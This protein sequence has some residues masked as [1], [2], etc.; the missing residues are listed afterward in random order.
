MLAAMT[1]AQ[2]QTVTTDTRFAR[3]ATMAFGRMT[4]TGIKSA[5]VA[6]QGFCWAEHAQ[7][8]VDDQKTTKFMSNN[9]RIYRLEKLTPATKY[10]M[11]AF[12]TTKDGQTYYG[13]ALK[14]YTVPKGQIT[15]TIRDGGSADVKQR[16]TD[17][18]KTAVDWWNNLTE[19]KGF[20]TSVGYESGTPTADC[21]YGGWIRVGSNTSY[22][23]TGTIMHEMLHGCGVIPWADTEWSRHNLRSGVTGD[24][25]GTGLWLGDRVTEVVRFLDNSATAQ[26]NGDYQ[27]MWPYGINGAHEDNGS[28]LLYIGNSLICQALGEDGLQHTYELFAEP[29]YAFDQEDDVKYY[30][31]NES[32]ACGLYSSYLVPTIAGQ[33][34]WRTM[35]VEEALANDSAAWYIT[36]KP[37]NQYY[38]FRN[39]ATERYISYLGS[40]LRTMARTTPT[41]SDNFHLMKSRVDVAV[42]GGTIGKRGYWVIAPTQNWTPPCMT[43]AANGRVTTTTFNIANSA[44]TQRWLLLTADEALETEAE[45]MAVLKEEVIRAVEQVRALASVPHTEDE[46]GTDDAL[47]AELERIE[48]LLATATSPSELQTLTDDAR[49]AAMAFLQN[50]TPSDMAHPFDLTAMLVSPDMNSGEGW[51]VAPTINYSCGE[52]YEKAFD[53][54]QKVDGLPAGTYAF[55]AQAFQRPGRPESC[56]GTVVNAYIYAGSK[57]EKLAHAVSEAQ[58]RKLGGS[59]SY[60]GGK[61]IPNNMEAASIYF[62]KGLYE[63]RVL[64]TVDSDGG[65]LKAGLRCAAMNSYYWVIFDNF[66]LYYYGSKSIDDVT[67]IYD[68]PICDLPICNSDNMRIYD[69]QGRMVNGQ[70]VNGKCVNGQSVNGKSVRIVNGRKVVIR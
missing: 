58:V 8:T 21:S 32:E 37:T 19:M 6:E 33:L 7:P 38:Q 2:A 48:S 11:R 30:I 41:T 44:D 42:G 12:V 13:D 55:C 70:S 1:T 5:D 25:Y 53:M 57:S 47:Q 27:H 35:T 18:V 40:G 26:L 69:L 67:G 29:Y 36:F 59:E 63:N 66:R 20:S 50:A 3:G 14:F 64:T 23:R 52:F 45:A 39:A 62:K 60:V 51:S 61:Y 54:N 10:Y 43:A 31:K 9:G 56:S 17:A 4:Y 24:G 34:Q 15:Y 22:Q 65:S 68:L 49:K 16:I 28:D 46:A